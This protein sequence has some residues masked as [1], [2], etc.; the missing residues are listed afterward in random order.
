MIIYKN[1]NNTYPNDPLRNLNFENYKRLAGDIVFFIGTIP[2]ESIYKNFDKKKIYFATEEQFNDCDLTKN[3]Y[4]FVDEILT[5][6]PTSVSKRDKRK[7]CFWPVDHELLKNVDIKDF[8][9]KEFDACYF[10]GN[11]GIHI[12]EIFDSMSEFKFCQ[13]N[14]NINVSYLDKLNLISK[15][16]ISV[17]H[18]LIIPYCGKGVTPQLKTRCFE[19][20]FCKSLMLVLKDEFN[21]IEEWFKPGED[22]IYYDFGNLKNTLS[23]VL[24]N[25]NKFKPM[26]ESAFKKCMNNYTTQHFVEK[27]LT[28]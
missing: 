23:E 17:C 10:G 7:F 24:N 2:P 21:T 1:F 5:I 14:H 16:K 20:G 9:D 18:N 22:F 4:N 15:S 28:I 3:Y 25:Y 26:V 27:Y 19:A 6:C 8:N 12:N 13:S 11:Y